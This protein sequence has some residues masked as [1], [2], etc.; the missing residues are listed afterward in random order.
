[1]T[2]L[3]RYPEVVEAAALGYAPHTLAHFLRDI[4]DAFHS[5][6]NAHTFLV[7]DAGLRNARLALALATRQVLASGLELL[8]V[9]APEAM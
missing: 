9:D 4:A 8:G 6:Y 5:Y 3:A 1:M 7:E 2:G